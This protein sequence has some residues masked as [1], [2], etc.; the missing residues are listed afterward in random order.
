MMSRRTF[1]GL[2]PPLVATISRGHASQQDEHKPILT[3][4]ELMMHATVRIE[5]TGADG[6]TSSG[7][8]FFFAMF[9]TPDGNVPVI[10]T[11]KHVFGQN[12]TAAFFLTLS[13]PDGSP[14]IGHMVRIDVHDLQGKWIGHSDPKVDLAILPC[15]EVL[16]QLTNQGQKPFIVFLDQSIIPS[17]EALK[18]LVPVEDILVVGYPDGIWDAR[19]N[20]PVFRCG[21]TATAPYLPFNGDTVFL[22]DCSIFPGSSGSPVF[23]FNAGSY[24]ARNGGLTVGS[25]LMFLGVVS[26]VALHTVAGKLIIEFAPTAVQSVPVTAIPNDLGICVMASRA[27]QFEPLL[28]KMGY[29]TP[30]GYNM[31]ANSP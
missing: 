14:D 31:R 20:A 27:L 15:A 29:T 4:T 21:I 22:I 23:L 17:E 26:A 1:V 13:K 30:S 2:I 5:C 16:Q 11:N 28:V 25:R 8:G 12:A 9:Q 7:T 6:S 18:T 10:M 19:N 3:P 24:P